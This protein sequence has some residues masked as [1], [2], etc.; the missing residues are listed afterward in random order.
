MNKRVRNIV[1]SGLLLALAVVLP[2]VFHQFQLQGRIFLPM[3]LPVLLAGLLIGPFS[4]L[5]VGILA[6]PLSFLLTGMLPPYALPMMALELPLYGLS[7]GII[8]N[9][10]KWH[11]LP[12][13]IIALIVGRIG[14]AA[15]FYA[16]GL[17]LALPYSPKTWL[18]ASAITGLPGIIIQL[19]AI[20]LLLPSLKKVF[21]KSG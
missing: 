4:G 1:Q 15:G 2:I 18:Y 14:F 13:L 10:L 3:H 9:K 21:P 5:L 20:P 19:V 17:F 12:A 11:P 8:A 6:P 7:I 16:V